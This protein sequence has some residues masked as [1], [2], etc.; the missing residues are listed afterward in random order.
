MNENEEKNMIIDIRV[1]KHNHWVAVK[2]SDSFGIEKGHVKDEWECDLCCYITVG[3]SIY[4][5]KV[6][7]YEKGKEREGKMKLV[8]SSCARRDYFKLSFG[9]RVWKIIENYER[10]GELNIRK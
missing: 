6:M 3:S 5:Y 2:G 4:F 7:C 8:C 1:A 10:M 9:E